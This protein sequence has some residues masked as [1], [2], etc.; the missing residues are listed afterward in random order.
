MQNFSCTHPIPQIESTQLAIGGHL[1]E[2]YEVSRRLVYSQLCY[3][4]FDSLDVLLYKNLVVHI[5]TP[6]LHQPNWQLGSFW[7]MVVKCPRGLLKATHLRK[8]TSSDPELL[9][10][11]TDAV[12]AIPKGDVDNKQTMLKG[13]LFEEAPKVASNGC[14]RVLWIFM[15]IF[16]PT[17]SGIK[18]RSISLPLST[19]YF[20]L[21]ICFKTLSKLWR[22]KDGGLLE[23]IWQ[24]LRCCTI[25]SLI[26]Q[27][28]SYA[29]QD[30][31]KVLQ[32]SPFY[33]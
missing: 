19:I 21:K 2:G 23:R 10:G 30:A 22:R 8:S 29:S 31:V 25:P 18:N 13:K 33:P 9:K 5:P 32:D 1:K 26:C 3:L 28:K 24:G 4:I 6:Q 27:Q 7:R 14:K 15:S 17:L 16:T 20:F 12:P 11:C